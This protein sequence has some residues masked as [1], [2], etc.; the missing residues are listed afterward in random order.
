[1]N[2]TWVNTRNDKLDL[3]LFTACCL[4]LLIVPVEGIQAYKKKVKLKKDFFVE[5]KYFKKQYQHKIKNFP[6]KKKTFKVRER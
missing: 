3:P 6:K 2:I 4:S 1:M 5:F